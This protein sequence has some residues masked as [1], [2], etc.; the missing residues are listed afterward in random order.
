MDFQIGR[1]VELLSRPPAALQ[2][3]LSDERPVRGDG[4]SRRRERTAR[5][6]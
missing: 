2:A 1:A 6:A 4:R 5:K 3:L